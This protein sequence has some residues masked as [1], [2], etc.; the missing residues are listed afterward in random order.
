MIHPREVFKP[1][2]A[3]SAHS[4]ILIHNHPSGDCKPSRK[5]IVVTRKI[6]EAGDLLEIKLI[7]HVIIGKNS[8]YSF[9]EQDRIN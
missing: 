9:K 7:D 8:Y 6:K 1:A 5:D 2:I 3:E 4:I